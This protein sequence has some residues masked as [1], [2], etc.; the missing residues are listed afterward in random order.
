MKTKQKPYIIYINENPD[1]FLMRKI[2]L[3]RRMKEHPKVIDPHEV[4]IVAE[5]DNS[6]FTVFAVVPDFTLNTIN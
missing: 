6:A 4:L 1:R 2:R 3:S 5:G